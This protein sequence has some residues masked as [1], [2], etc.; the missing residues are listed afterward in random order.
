MEKNVKSI[1]DA[2]CSYV[3]FDAAMAKRLNEYRIGFENKN[4]EHMTFFGGNLT[5]V[6]IV[7]FTTQD[8]EKWFTDVLEIDDISLEEKILELP[9]INA[10]WH[11]S[12]DVFN[13]SV[14]WAIHSLMNS[15][16]LNDSQKHAAMMDAALVLQFKFLTSL[17]FNYWRYPANAEVAAAAYAQLSNKFA[18]KQHGSWSATLRN[19][20]EDLLNE[21]GIHRQCFM[22]FNN[23]HLIVRTLND[24]QSRIRDMAKGIRGVFDKVHKSGDRISSTS[25]TAEFEG[26]E[27]L[28]DKT[29]SLNSYTRYLNSII[30]DKN[31]FIKNEL[32]D[33]VCRVQ[34]TMPP[35]IFNKTLE[36]ISINYRHTEAKEIEELV[37]MCLLHSFTYL[38][39]HRNKPRE[40]NDLASLVSNLRG[41]YMSSR[42]TDEELLA[43]RNKAEVIVIKAAHTKNDSVIASVRTGLLL[44]FILR[45]YTMHHYS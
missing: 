28:K 1:F 13:I 22:K 30:T 35:K 6:Q 20:C 41:I 37:E 42:S 18:L 9:T 43:L 31:S 24:S 44:Y 26:E 38:T 11:V 16:L 5:G 10:D 34:Y 33:V 21:E 8:K 25:M 29:K 14:I 45:A 3:R 36:W 7:R 4:E 23:D 15:H 17:L 2:E 32:V 27:I 40:T 19:R 12:S 39:D